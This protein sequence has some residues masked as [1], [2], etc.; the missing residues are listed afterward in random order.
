MIIRSLYN[1]TR[2]MNVLQK[3]QENNSAN[4][5]NVNTPGYKMQDL[6]QK[7][8]EEHELYNHAGGTGNNRKVLLGTMNFGTEIDGAVTNFTQ[9]SLKETGSATD[10]ALNGQG[11]FTLALENGETGFTRNG[12]FRIS[13]D[14]RLVT[15]EGYPVMGRTAQGTPTEIFVVGDQLTVSQEGYIN[16]TDVRLMLSNFQDTAA[17]ELRGESIYMTEEGNP[18]VSDAEVRQG[19]LENANV[20]IMDEIVKM[21]EVSREFQSNQRVLSVLNDTLQKT[22]NEI[23]RN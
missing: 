8:M 7:S 19:S 11:F 21:M 3:R 13:E 20:N 5:A 9:G 15:Q 17:F 14:Q 1:V 22:V 6:I 10:L 4:A 2:Q 12:N 18:L 16:G 23:G